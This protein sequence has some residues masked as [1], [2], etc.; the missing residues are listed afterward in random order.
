M[1]KNAECTFGILK[2]RWRILKSGIRIHSIESADKIFK[3]CCAL[4]NYLLDADGLDLPWEDAFLCEYEHK[5]FEDCN[6]SDM[7]NAVHES[8]HEYGNLNEIDFSSV[9]NNNLRLFDNFNT[10]SI[11]D[12]EDENDF[13]SQ[14][15]NL[16]VPNYCSARRATDLPFEYFRSKLVEHFDILFT[17]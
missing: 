3:T 9:G 10:E 14:V 15:V 6:A 16:A 4:H 12:S 5:D 1:R 8:Y 11:N 13:V 17:K 7:P 2:Q